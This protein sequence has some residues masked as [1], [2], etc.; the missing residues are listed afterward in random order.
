[1][2]VSVKPNYKDAGGTVAVETAWL[3]YTGYFKERL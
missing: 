1:M 2:D 3:S